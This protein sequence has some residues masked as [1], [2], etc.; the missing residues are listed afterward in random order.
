MERPPALGQRF[1]TCTSFRLRLYI[2][3]DFYSGVASRYT[4]TASDLLPR[5]PACSADD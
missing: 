4:T 3:V 5:L 2:V 1:H